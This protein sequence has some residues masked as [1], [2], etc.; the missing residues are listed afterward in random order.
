TK[1]ANE[2]GICDMSGNVYEWC[3]DWY[4]AY[5]AS[6]Q[7]NPT[8]ASTDDD[9]VVRGGCW[10]YSAVFCRVADRYSNSP[11]HR[12]LMGFRLVLS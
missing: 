3:Q 1:K 6:S 7:Q 10:G 12:Y 5:S 9:R 11:D 2:L 4:G 8:D